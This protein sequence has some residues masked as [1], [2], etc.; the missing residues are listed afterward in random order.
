MGY[1][2][3]CPISSS[4][5]ET[6]QHTT[7]VFK[8]LRF[9]VFAISDFEVGIDPLTA[10][11]FHTLGIAEPAQ[12]LLEHRPRGHNHAR[13]VHVEC[14]VEPQALEVR[15]F[16]SSVVAT[17]ASGLSRLGFSHGINRRSAC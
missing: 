10:R 3:V 5:V 7:V 2:G 12:Y 9:S 4:E 6:V 8:L 1:V 13:S 11:R 16:R 17:L 14:G 15:C